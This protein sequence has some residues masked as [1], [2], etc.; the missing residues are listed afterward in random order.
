MSSLLILALLRILK[1]K[2]P[3][4]L[5][6]ASTLAHLGNSAAIRFYQSQGIGRIVLPRHLTVAE[7]AEVHAQT[8]EMDCDAFL[9]VGKCPNTEGLCTFHHS[10]PDKIWPCEVPYSVEAVQQLVSEDLRLAMERQR[11]WA[12]SDR[13]HGCGLCAIPQL[14]KA[15]ISG[16]KL[17]GRGAPTRRKVKNLLITKKFVQLAEEIELF[18]DY[19][20]EAM[21]AHREH[22]GIGCCENVCYYPEFYNQG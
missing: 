8:P 10:S 18:D 4:L 15:G 20:A 3:Q 16:L 22:F 7:M 14:I 12:D 19:R 9:L 5:Y 6:H 13:R 2:F 17:V 21:R 11:G 1:R